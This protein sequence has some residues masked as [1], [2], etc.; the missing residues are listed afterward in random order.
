M[1]ETTFEL[2]VRTEDFFKGIGSSKIIE[3]TKTYTQKSSYFKS[4]NG[5]S[6]KLRAETYFEEIWNVKWKRSVKE[7]RMGDVLASE[8]DEGRGKLR[9]ASVSR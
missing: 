9:K 3:R 2:R 4:S 6:S 5:S 1:L 7:G 8:G